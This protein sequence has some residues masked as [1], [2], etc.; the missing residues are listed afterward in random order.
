MYFEDACRLQNSSR[1]LRTTSHLVGHLMREI[2]SSIRSVLRV[3]TDQD[4][5]VGSTDL[6]DRAVRISAIL[7]EFPELQ[8]KDG[9]SHRA[10]IRSILRGLGIEKK[11]VADIWIKTAPKHAHSWAHRDNLNLPRPVDPDFR[12]YLDK[13]ETVFDLLIPEF[14]AKYSAVHKALE[15]MLSKAIPTREDAKWLKTQVPNNR[16]GIGHFFTKLE[17]PKWLLPLDS[18]GLFLHP[19]E[20]QF[21]E[22]TGSTS[23]AN[24]PAS[25]YLMRMAKL[26]EPET[27]AKV[28]EILGK[29]ATSNYVVHLD[30]LQAACDLPLE[31]VQPIAD[32]ELAWLSENTLFDTLLPDKVANLVNHLSGLGDVERA[33]AF[34]RITLSPVPRNVEQLNETEDV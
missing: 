21:D 31:L 7:E 26:D 3:I 20:P 29:I 25:R 27:K 1:P 8:F 4:Q 19:P 2:E 10:Q 30:I 9:E 13:M 32:K 24:W 18:E 16:P 34:S 15:H 33:L 5:S 14:E 22:E 17:N 28:A 23:F 11:L 12:D 6:E